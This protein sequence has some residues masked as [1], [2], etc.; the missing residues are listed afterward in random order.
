MLLFSTAT[1]PSLRLKDPCEALTNDLATRYVLSGDIHEAISEFNSPGSLFQNEGR[2][3]AFDMEIIFHSRAKNSFSQ[4]RLCTQHHFQS[5]GFWNSEVAY[6]SRLGC[7]TEMH[8]REVENAVQ[9]FYNNLF[10]IITFTSQNFRQKPLKIQEQKDQW[11]L[12][13]AGHLRLISEFGVPAVDYKIACD[14]ERVGIKVASI[15]SS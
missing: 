8:N 13:L 5:E 15:C 3:S 9:L 2:C 1:L 11:E 6:C 14:W 12:Q 7:V 10:F 4:E